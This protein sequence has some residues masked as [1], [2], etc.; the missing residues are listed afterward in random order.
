MNIV[1]TSSNAYSKCTGISLFSLLYNN[2]DIDDLDIYILTTDMD[3]MNKQ[4][5]S[6]MCLEFGRRVFIIDVSPT[7]QAAQQ[8]LNLASYRGGLNTY[9]RAMA[10]QIL[11]TSLKDA[12]FIDSDTLVCSSLVN[13]YD[14]VNDDKVLYGVEEIMLLI[15]GLCREDKDL[16]D[17]CQHYLNCGILFIDLEKWRELSGDEM[18]ATCVKSYGRQFKVAEQSIL[19]YT[20]NK[21]IGLLPPKYNYYT[22][23]HGI[24]YN[25]ISKR[26]KKRR[27]FTK[28]QIDDAKQSPVIIHFVGD[29]WIRPWYQDNDCYY[30]IL[31]YN[32]YK[33]SPWGDKKLD[34]APSYSTLFKLYFRF[35]RIIKKIGNGGMYFRFRYVFMEW[36]HEHFPKI[37]KL[38]E[39]DKRM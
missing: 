35:L 14:C 39:I 33:K 27:I 6:S 3:E 9:A 29:H 11:P 28:E 24:N 19:N 34:E 22:V 16:F 30:R 26:Y 21:Y 20:F 36:M 7:L 4:K 10:N 15:K 31:Y 8:K 23:L 37:E 38:R 2:R 1:Y 13:I 17:S 25:T 32:Y 5:I 18:I 12:L